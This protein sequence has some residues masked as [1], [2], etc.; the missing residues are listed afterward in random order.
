VHKKSLIA[1][2][3]DKMGFFMKKNYF[4]MNSHKRKLRLLKNNSSCHNNSSVFEEKSAVHLTEQRQE[5]RVKLRKEAQ[6]KIA[7]ENL[8]LFNRLVQQKSRV[9]P[10]EQFPSLPLVKKRKR[11]V[12]S[13]DTEADVIAKGERTVDN[14][15][16]CQS[17]MSNRGKV[18]HRHSSSKHTTSYLSNNSK[19]SQDEVILP[20]IEKMKAPVEDHLDKFIDLSKLC[21][22]PSKTEKGSRNKT[23]L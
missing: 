14:D 18:K 8:R 21:N 15:S 11:L 4:E 13:F 9:F 12:Y 2:K 10:R 1:N 17:K 22:R 7:V 6:T 16:H 19:F 20:P 5:H 3:S 23:E